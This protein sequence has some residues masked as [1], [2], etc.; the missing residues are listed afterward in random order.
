MESD[1]TGHLTSF[2][3][4]YKYMHRGIHTWTYVPH[5][6]PMMHVHALTYT[7]MHSHAC[8]Q[9]N[10]GV[11]TGCVTKDLAQA[12]SYTNTLP[13]SYRFLPKS[14]NYNT[15]RR[16][17]VECVMQIVNTGSELWKKRESKESNQRLQLDILSV[18]GR[19]ERFRKDDMNRNLDDRK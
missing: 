16:D 7:C 13:L 1:R 14:F 3:S 15:E 5:T 17:C 11:G 2:S 19:G 12:T 10:L 6:Y 18:R 9:K 4:F 8:T